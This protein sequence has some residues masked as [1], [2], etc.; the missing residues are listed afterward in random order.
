[1]R[2]I[3]MDKLF[4]GMPVWRN[5]PP[6][7]QSRRGLASNLRQLQG[8]PVTL[9]SGHAKDDQVGQI[10]EWLKSMGVD[11]PVSRQCDGKPM[12][13]EI[14]VAMD[15]TTGELIVVKKNQDGGERTV[16]TPTKIDSFSDLTAF[17]DADPNAELR[18]SLES[19]RRV[20]EDYATLLA[21]MA[22]AN[23]S[24]VNIPGARG[25]SGSIRVKGGQIYRGDTPVKIEPD[26]D[27]VNAFARLKSLVAEA[28]DIESR[29]TISLKNSKEKLREQVVK[30][31]DAAISAMKN[32][33]SQV[34]DLKNPYVSESSY[35]AIRSALE[36]G[37]SAY[38]NLAWLTDGLAKL[39]QEWDTT[40]GQEQIQVAQELLY[41]LGM[42]KE[43]LVSGNML[44][45]MGDRL[46]EDYREDVVRF[47]QELPEL[48]AEGNAAKMDAAR[49][50]S[51]EYRSVARKPSAAEDA[52]RKAEESWAR[53]SPSDRAK[54][55]K[56]G[57]V[58]KHI[59]ETLPDEVSEAVRLAVEEAFTGVDFPGVA[60]VKDDLLSSAKGGDMPFR[61]AITN[62]PGFALWYNALPDNVRALVPQNSIRPL[63]RRWVLGDKEGVKAVIR[64]Q[65]G[66][67]DGVE[68]EGK[69]KERYD[70]WKGKVDK[71]Y[72]TL[73]VLPQ[74]QQ[75]RAKASADEKLRQYRQLKDEV[76]R[77]EGRLESVE[78]EA[79]SGRRRPQGSR[80]QLAYERNIASL[81][82]QLQRK[83]AKV[84]NDA[85]DFKRT[86]TPE[87]RAAYW[88]DRGE[89]EMK[90]SLKRLRQSQHD[91]EQLAAQRE[92]IKTREDWLGL[93]KVKPETFSVALDAIGRAM[94]AV[95]YDPKTGQPL[96]PGETPTQD[97]VDRLASAVQQAQDMQKREKQLRDYDGKIAQGAELLAKLQTPPDAKEQVAV[98]D[99]I[100]EKEAPTDKQAQDDAQAALPIT[101]ISEEEKQATAY[102]AAYAA[103][104]ATP[105]P[106]ELAEAKKRLDEWKYSDSRDTNAALNA[107]Y[108]AAW[109]KMLQQSKQPAD[110]TPKPAEP[111]QD[112]V[113]TAIKFFQ[114]YASGTAQYP[115]EKVK[116]QLETWGKSPLR[117]TD[118]S[119]KAAYN[120]AWAKVLQQPKQPAAA[121]PGVVQRA[122]VVKRT[123][124]AIMHLQGFSVPRLIALTKAVKEKPD[125]ATAIR[126]LVPVVRRT[127][128]IVQASIPVLDDSWKKQ[129]TTIVA[130]GRDAMVNAERELRSIKPQTT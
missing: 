44:A 54:L 77:V 118:E 45:R 101:T 61:R 94:T 129:A 10:T 99:E 105:T 39:G 81:R 24:E 128:D 51:I 71:S 87:E 86:I 25:Y 27:G 93:E 8:K 97:K 53:M 76:R 69:E 18:V 108:N 33:Q 37:Q 74:E 29:L 20:T 125:T 114:D 52:R 2:V 9:V 117:W 50:Q 73:N 58:P 57:R 126:E 19:F 21:L 92:E 68:M 66:V 111:S 31:M 75:A 115:L 102:F 12:W 23:K 78:K 130:Q 63:F 109:A 60:D 5:P 89:K 91:K 26:A 64:G 110:A 95:T 82:E 42:A 14:E 123:Q 40:K 85:D 107:A 90:A 72:S 56:E 83:L 84:R 88:K 80:D 41:R 30:E 34:Q 7:G 3:D 55:V 17:N 49:R 47:L 1:M 6:V 121:P 16:Y 62:A 38:P 119:L 32:I 15:E 116:E 113:N 36:R 106:D 13:E 100:K 103:S 65:Y 11:L 67:V 79:K 104:T 35:K 28:R 96:K 48:L 120:A 122:D 59:L 43:L 4:G 112:N 98:T 22:G 46:S 127:V 70:Y 124:D